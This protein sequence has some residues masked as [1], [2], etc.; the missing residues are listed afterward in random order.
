MTS[1]E[2]DLGSMSMGPGA[3][4]SEITDEDFDDRDRGYRF[5]QTTT[6]RVLHEVFGWRA[7]GNDDEKEGGGSF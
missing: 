3:P 5:P 7:D 2:E 4:G 1:I 6:F